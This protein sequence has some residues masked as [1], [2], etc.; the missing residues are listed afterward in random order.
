METPGRFI[1]CVADGTAMETTNE[2]QL[3]EELRRC[4]ACFEWIE[5]K[6]FKLNRNN[7]ILYFHPFCFYCLT[8][9]NPNYKSLYDNYIISQKQY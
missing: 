8:H 5:L 2:Y 4:D 3:K 6:V 1:P 9:K 7:K